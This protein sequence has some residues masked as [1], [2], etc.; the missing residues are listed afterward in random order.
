MIYDALSVY[1]LQ[2]NTCFVCMRRRRVCLPTLTIS[3]GTSLLRCPRLKA[4]VAHGA[5]EAEAAEPIGLD[6]HR[7]R[8]A[9]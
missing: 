8:P 6:I 9:S 3:L 1:F 4:A 5:G 2:W 7:T